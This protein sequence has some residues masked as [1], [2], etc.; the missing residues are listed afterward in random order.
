MSEIV[1]SAVV[2]IRA[3]TDGLAK[4]IET[5]VKK[6]VSGVNPDSSSSTLGSRIAKSISSG[7]TKESKPLDTNI[8][9]KSFSS[10]ESSAAKLGN[11]IGKDLGSAISK[12]LGKS[13]SELG[14]ISKKGFDAVESGVGSLENKLK[15]S[16]SRIAVAAGAAFSFQQAK[17]FLESTIDLGAKL[18]KQFEANAVLFGSSSTA[19]VSFAKNAATSLGITETQA[20]AATQSFGQLLR[21]LQIGQA[22]AAD[23]STKLVQLAGDLANFKQIDVT[24]AT[25]ALQTGLTGNTRGLKALGISLDAAA[26]KQEAL[27]LGLIN[28]KV[29]LT[30]SQRTEA[31]KQEAINEGLLKSG[32]TLTTAI[33]AQVETQLALKGGLDNSTA[34]L[35][36]AIKAQAIYA[37]ILKQTGLEQGTFAKT[38]GD[39]ANQQVIL[40]A[41]LA[42]AKA[43]LGQGLL[44]AATSIVSFL[45]QS[46][47]PLITQLAG[48]ISGPLNDA[49]QTLSSVFQ[50]VARKFQEGGALAEGAGTSFST[51]TGEIQGLSKQFSAIA[52]SIGKLVEAVVPI[53]GQLVGLLGGAFLTKIGTIIPIITDL[54][55]ALGPPLVT[56]IDTLSIAFQKLAPI[57]GDTIGLAIASLSPIVERLIFNLSNFILVVAQAII[58]ILQEFAPVITAVVG[59]ILNFIGILLTGLGPTIVTLGPVIAS[60]LNLLSVSFI[61]VIQT[62]ITS[63]EPLIPLIGQAL[64]HALITIIPLIPVFVDLISS[65][66]PVIITLVQDLLPI[67]IT[68]LSSLVPVIA[69]LGDA[70]LSVLKA[71][72]PLIPILAG[73]FLTILQALLPILPQLANAIVQLV[74]PL[75]AQLAPILPQL[76]DAFVQIVTALLPLIPLILQLVPPLVQGLLPILPELVAQFQIF[77]NIITILVPIITPL[78]N[79]FDAI[80][81]VLAPLLPILLPLILIFTGI[82]GPIVFATAAFV[83]LEPTIKA[84]AGVIKDIIP[85]I[86]R[87]IELII[88]MGKEFVDKFVAGFKIAVDDFGKGIDRIKQFFIDLPGNVEK[89]LIKFKDAVIASIKRL[90]GLIETAAKDLFKGLLLAFIV[91]PAV[92]IIELIRFQVAITRFFLFTAPKA[93]A[94]AAVDLFHGVVDAFNILEDFLITGLPKIID[95]VVTFFS[96]TAPKAI[97]DAAKDVFH[98]I[99]DAAIS[100]NDFLMKKIPQIFDDVVTFLFTTVPQKLHDVAAHLWDELTNSASNASDQIISFFTGLPDKISAL[101][102]SFISAGKGLGE[103]IINGII[104]GVTGATDIFI[105]FSEGLAQAVKDVVN[106]SIIDKIN[107]FSIS[108]AGVTLDIPKEFQIPQ[109]ATGGIALSK[110]GGTLANLG[111]AGSNEAIIPLNGQGVSVLAATMEAALRSISPSK[112]PQATS[113]AGLNTSP[114]IGQMTVVGSEPIETSRQVVKRLKDIQNTVVR[115]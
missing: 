46:F 48:A 85:P 14:S 103:S 78:L 47:L 98:G 23:M 4:D 21:G 66:L 90:P 86:E 32:D 75:A 60:L 38:S 55:N 91:L 9:S 94:D 84:V 101:A 40:T 50:D 102:D 1:G 54:T 53:I 17:Q 109:L 27:D 29:K 2:T 113:L 73:A 95:N 42:N 59:S 63:I 61:Q 89:E 99:V 35:T 19:V 44:P 6:S 37:L 107:N 11:T 112:G 77:A 49:L 76:A 67:F 80:I 82:G 15:S 57:F 52:P 106:H 72:E 88:Q 5:Q 45:A 68:L 43:E 62:L 81:K 83:L 31:I 33:R 93:I 41:E 16:F 39:L 28:S 110:P 12:D 58:P 100:L 87:F 34:S 65:I 20:L 64:V 104:N 24:T 97:G 79:A 69:P 114:L 108:F 30:A 13:F 115:R 70:F 74:G 22:P 26:I 36:P 105:N 92:A 3:N 10:L 25:K 7:F 18:Q 71:I 111:E 96:V 51:I 8:F 56:V